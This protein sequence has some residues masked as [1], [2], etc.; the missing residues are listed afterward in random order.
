MVGNVFEWCTD[1]YSEYP[2]GDMMD[3]QGPETGQ[4]RVYRGARWTDDPDNCRFA[5][6]SDMPPGTN[7]VNSGFRV[8]LDAEQSF[9]LNTWKVLLT[10]YYVG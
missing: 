4:S 1:W 3:P 9:G 10:M 5:G 6:R 7:G 8:A 2:P